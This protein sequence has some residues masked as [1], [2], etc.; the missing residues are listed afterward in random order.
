MSQP[1]RGLTLGLVAAGALIAGVVV[2]S[3]FFKPATTGA[4]EISSGTLLPQPRPIPEFV[5]A[6]DDGQPFTPAALAGKWSV[7]F[8]GFTH[9]PDICPNTLGLLKNVHKQLA[10]QNKRLQ[11]VLLS[12]DPERDTPEVLSRYVKYF[13]SS[14]VGAT[15]PKEQLDPL[16]SALGF[17]YMKV[18]G[19]TPETYS[20]DHSSALILVNPQGQ[21]AGYFTQPLKIEALTADLAKLIPSAS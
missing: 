18:P 4:V 2:A 9:C 10:A 6:G 15:G 8:V 1:I 7:I 12:V 5:L 16:G 17:I 11:V 14:F 3:L 19:A 13:D 20:V 21:V